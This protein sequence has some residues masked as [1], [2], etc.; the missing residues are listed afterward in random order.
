MTC[1]PRSSLARRRRQRSLVRPPARR[2]R[3]VVG[4]R[5]SSGRPTT[6]VRCPQSGRGTNL[7]AEVGTRPAPLGRTARP[8]QRAS[9]EVLD[10]TLPPVRLLPP[11][12]SRASYQRQSRIQSPS[13]WPA[14]AAYRTTSAL[15]ALPL[16][17]ALAAVRVPDS[18]SSSTAGEY[19]PLILGVSRP[20]G[21]PVAQ[22]RDRG[23]VHVRV[24]GER[25]RQRAAAQAA[26]PARTATT[27][28]DSAHPCRAP[29]ARPGTHR[30]PLTVGA[31]TPDPRARPGAARCGGD[32]QAHTCRGR[33]G[34]APAG[35][36]EPVRPPSPVGVDQLTVIS[37]YMPAA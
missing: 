23:A 4:A 36:P 21:A 26:A 16:T 15:R 27:A 30:R 9:L 31:R 34:S 5:S 1:T 32:G 28:R 13:S 2:S 3:Q 10:R 17:T 35:G 37:A 12:R 8:G 20:T 18:S 11:V 7:L 14:F 22:S 6:A 33:T 29:S 19:S 25:R 24:L